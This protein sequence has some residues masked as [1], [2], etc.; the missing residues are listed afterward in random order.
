MALE[1]AA[2]HSRNVV[3]IERMIADEP[4][5]NAGAGAGAHSHGGGM[6]GMM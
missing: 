5:E 2:Y 3:T 1:N 4:E 6:G